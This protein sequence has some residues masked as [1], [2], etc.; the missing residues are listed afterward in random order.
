[1]KAPRIFAQS[2]GAVEYT[3]YFSADGSGPTNESPGYG[4]KQSD[5]EILVMLEL[6]GMR[7]ISSVPSLPVPPDRSYLW[8]K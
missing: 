1:M 2:A 6:W 3:D 8:V 4:T 5:I 7:S